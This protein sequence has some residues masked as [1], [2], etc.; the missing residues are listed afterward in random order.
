MAWRRGSERKTRGRSACVSHWMPHLL[1]GVKATFHSELDR[2][3]IDHGDVI[4]GIWYLYQLF[5]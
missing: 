5:E 1:A 3:E 4:D 2:H